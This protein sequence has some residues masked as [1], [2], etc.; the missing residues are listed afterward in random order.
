MGVE[1]VVGLNRN[2]TNTQGLSPA[3]LGEGAWGPA[4]PA[5]PSSRSGE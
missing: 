2:P 3:A 5:A 1:P 4:L